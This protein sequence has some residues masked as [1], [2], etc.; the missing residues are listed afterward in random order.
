MLMSLRLSK[1]LESELIRAARQ[2][3]VSKSEFLRRCLKKELQAEEPRSTAYELGKDL[4][5]KYA[6]GRSDLAENAEQIV[7]EKI[8]AKARRGGYG[9]AGR[10]VRS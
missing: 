9:P 3:G 4:F 6:S 8:H 10:S 7:R 1:K 5:G 2:A